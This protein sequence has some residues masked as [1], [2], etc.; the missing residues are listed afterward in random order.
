MEKNNQFPKL[1]KC[2]Y[3]KKNGFLYNPA[4]GEITSPTGN[5]LK[6]ISSRGY[7][8]IAFYR[9]K[10][11]YQVR[12]HDFAFFMM[13]GVIPE[14]VKHINVIKN[15]DRINNLQPTTHQEICFEGKAKGFCLDKRQNKF[16]AQIVRNKKNIYLGTFDTAEEAQKAFEKARKNPDNIRSRKAIKA[17]IIATSRVC[18]GCKVEKPLE[19]FFRHKK[20]VH[21]R[22]HKCKI[23]MSEIRKK[24]YAQ[25]KEKI[26]E[27]STAT[28]FP[29]KIAE[30]KK[31]YYEKNREKIKEHQKNWYLKKKE[32]EKK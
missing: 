19:E 13:H 11:I 15:D 2:Q 32:S 23:C 29:E 24:Y 5:T 4:T 20:Y 7:T 17:S 31:K 26:K 28:K 3:F 6:S 25:N 16:K 12:A 30:Y 22:Y 27:S 18:T 1:E 14:R 8:C 10:K 9:D 21:G